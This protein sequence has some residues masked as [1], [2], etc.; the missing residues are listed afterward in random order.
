MLSGSCPGVKEAAKDVPDR[1]GLAG[2]V[3]EDK[4][5]RYRLD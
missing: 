5:E 2:P 1:P 3:D 4:V